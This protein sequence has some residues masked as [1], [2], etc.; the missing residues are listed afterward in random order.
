MTKQDI[1]DYVA[2]RYAN[3]FGQRNTDRLSAMLDE[4]IVSSAQKAETE[5]KELEEKLEDMKLDIKE[6]Y[7]ND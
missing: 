5:L 2:L 1:L 7:D 6:E 3:G 4:L